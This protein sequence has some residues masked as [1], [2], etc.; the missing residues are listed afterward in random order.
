MEPNLVVVAVV[1]AMIVTAALILN[2][3]VKD[4]ARRWMEKEEPLPQ[5]NR[6]EEYVEAYIAEHTTPEMIQRR[7]KEKQEKIEWKAEYEDACSKG[8][9][10]KIRKRLDKG[11]ETDGNILNIIRLLEKRHGWD[12]PRTQEAVQY[13]Q[14][15]MLNSQWH[16]AISRLN[17]KQ[18]FYEG[19]D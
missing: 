8:E 11:E 14:R 9:L 16:S 6:V 19:N 5:L 10:F 7:I 15:I 13:H 3:E 17:N 4:F 2:V 12:D 18:K 1:I